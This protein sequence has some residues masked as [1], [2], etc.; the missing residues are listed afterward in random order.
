MQLERSASIATAIVD[1]SHGHL[2]LRDA[3][4][5]EVALDNEEHEI[6]EHSHLERSRR[7]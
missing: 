7:P 5:N 3:V 1:T 4:L 2:A 6:V